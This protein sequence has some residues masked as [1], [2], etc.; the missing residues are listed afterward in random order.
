VSP[1]ILIAIAI[2]I[3]ALSL[4]AS[5]MIAGDTNSAWLRTLVLAYSRKTGVPA[6]LIY[7]VVMQESRG[8]PRAQNPSDPSTGLMG[9]MPLIGRAYAN[10]TG[11]DAEVLE[12]LFDPDANMTAGTNF[13]AHLQTRYASKYDFQV[14]VQAYNLGE[15]KFDKGTRVPAYGAGVAQF[16]TQWSMPTL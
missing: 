14:W 1:F 12:K 3:I 10:L 4:G 16:A 5:N 13:L 7:G 2:G 15:T 9:I 8:N 6:S 11:T